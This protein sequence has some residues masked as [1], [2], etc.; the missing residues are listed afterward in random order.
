M[1]AYQNPSINSKF[2]QKSSSFNV[3]GA[4]V[5]AL[6]PQNDS[7]RGAADLVG[8]RDRRQGSCDDEQDLVMICTL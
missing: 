5:L 4:S 1:E 2:C 6:S 8:G 7:I 3:K